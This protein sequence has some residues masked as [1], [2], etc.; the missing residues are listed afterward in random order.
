MS[1]WRRFL[2]WMASLLGGGGPRALPPGPRPAPDPGGGAFVRELL[3]AAM[4]TADTDAWLD[5]LRADLPFPQPPFGATEPPKD[6]AEITTRLSALDAEI[7]AAV[8][9]GE[10]AALSTEAEPDW[11]VTLA[12]HFLPL[13]AWYA[14]VGLTPA[15]PPANPLERLRD[16]VNDT[17]KIDLVRRHLQNALDSLKEPI[18]RLT[19]KADGL[20][21][22]NAGMQAAYFALLQVHFEAVLRVLAGGDGASV[23]FGFPEP[24]ARVA[25]LVPPPV[26]A[27][28][29]VVARVLCPSVTVKL[30]HAAWS[31]GAHVRTR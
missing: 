8:E 7:R 28:S 14:G 31:R 30:P 25:D 26:G 11:F 21:R 27:T 23:G 29:G 17:M 9:R 12:D 15:E 16:L 13:A 22:H 24:G 5:H 10:G 2:R 6:T 3:G 4:T 20:A 18:L 1:L 19:Q